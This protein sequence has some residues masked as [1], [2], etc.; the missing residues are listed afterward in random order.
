MFAVVETRIGKIQE[1]DFYLIFS[2]LI[3]KVVNK[4]TINLFKAS[5]DFRLS[6]FI[7][8]AGFELTTCDF[9]K[10]KNNES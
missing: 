1:K 4:I 8:L 3:L 6:S 5:E 9:K 10:L 2:F 7:W